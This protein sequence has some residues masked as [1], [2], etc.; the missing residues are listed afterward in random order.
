MTVREL[1]ESLGLEVEAGARS[2]M[3]AVVHGTIETQQLDYNT[4]L[5]EDHV[6]LDQTI[7]EVSFNHPEKLLGIVVE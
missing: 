2:Y 4:V 5:V 1:L 3:P 6:E 7:S